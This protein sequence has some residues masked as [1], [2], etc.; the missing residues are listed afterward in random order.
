M[1]SMLENLIKTLP[2]FRHAELRQQL[3][4]LDHEIDLHYKSDADRELAK[5]AD[6]QGLGGSLGVEPAFRTTTR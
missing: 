4:L 1:R 5:I 3:K 6:S 2:D